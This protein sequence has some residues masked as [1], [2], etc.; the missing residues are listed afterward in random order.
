MSTPEIRFAMG[1]DAIAEGAIAA[2]ARFYAGY[3][4]TPS[5]EVAEISSYRLPQV[6][7]LFVQ[8]EDEIGSMAAII[9]ASA[10]GKKSYTA[11]SGPGISLMQENLGVAV[12][13]EVPCVI[14]NVQR[15]GPSTGLATKPGQG[16]LMQARW[17]T[18]GDHGII[19]L[20]PTSVQECYDLTIRA[21][22]LA[23]KYRTPVYLLADE[24][25]G[26]MREQYVLHQ[27]FEVIDRKQ[28][29][30]SIPAGDFKPFDFEKYEDHIAPMPAYGGKYIFRMNGS[31]HDE[32]GFGSMKPAN[33]SKFVHHY[34]DKIEKNRDDIVQVESYGMEDAE[35]AVISFGCSVRP[36][37]AAMRIARAQGM[38][39]GV[40]KLLTVWPFPDRE[41]AEVLSRVKCAA[42]PEMNLGQLLS[43]VKRYN[44]KRIPIVGVNRVD[45]EI[46]TPYQ[47]IDALKEAAK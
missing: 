16:D 26:H 19:A 27:N 12:M 15:S 30:E 23:E 46:V 13:S 43:E 17:G 41:V 21:F 42:V 29:D 14:I 45:S 1:N 18:H 36:A 2:G 37:M 25:V 31:G 4:I 10:A 11:T 6:G 3:P 38:K 7:G 39:V 28:P 35:Y 5:S 32:A 40:L 34:V 24:V 9:G 44:D 20:S 47:I 33:T 8:M 22:N